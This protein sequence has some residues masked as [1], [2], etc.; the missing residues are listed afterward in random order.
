MREVKGHQGGILL[1]GFVGVGDCA[2]ATRAHQS[3]FIN[4]RYMKSAV[5]SSAIESACR[6]HL[7]QGRYPSCVVHLT[8][9][10]EMVDVNVHPNKLE[11][12]FQDDASLFAAIEAIVKDAFTQK[13]PMA[14]AAVMEL[15]PAKPAA[16][17]PV[18]VAKTATVIPTSWTFLRLPPIG[19][20]SGGVNAGSS[21][22]FIRCF[23]ALET[24]LPK[25]SQ[26]RSE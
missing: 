23:A 22:V 6:E 20:S 17:A 12:R 8:M 5:L 24:K 13:D 7:M 9:P 18:T 16:T 2:R 15:S 3:F 21:S 4:G 19:M 10:F 1:S 26:N 14:H 11:C 25:I